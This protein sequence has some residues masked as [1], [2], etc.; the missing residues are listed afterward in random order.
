MNERADWLGWSIQFIVG[1]VAGAFSSLVFVRG[2][3]RSIPL[4]AQH[5]SP[6]FTL[7]L[8]LI[9]AAVASRYGDAYWIGTSYSI[10]PPD[11]PKQSAA[12]RRSSLVVGCVGGVLVLVALAR[13]F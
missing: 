11:E 10:I 9:G 8:A 5:T 13:S 12:S 4:I 7:G 1:F 2:G 3:R 6:T